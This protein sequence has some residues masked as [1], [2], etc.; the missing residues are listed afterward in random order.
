MNTL[1]TDFIVFLPILTCLKLALT[2][3]KTDFI[4]KS[5]LSLFCH[6]EGSRPIFGAGKF[7][8]VPA[9]DCNRTYLG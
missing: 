1:M 4:F 8:Q 6:L 2:P 7:C 5:K 3:F 9:P